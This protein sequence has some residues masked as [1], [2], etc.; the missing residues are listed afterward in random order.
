[1]CAGSRRFEIVPIL[2]PTVAIELCQSLDEGLF[3]D[4]DEAIAGTVALPRS[5]SADFCAD[6]CTVQANNANRRVKILFIVRRD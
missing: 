6:T 3:V 4:R 5:V 2:C 1:M